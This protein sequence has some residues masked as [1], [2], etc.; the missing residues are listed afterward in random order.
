MK[1]PQ[2]KISRARC[3]SNFRW[4]IKAVDN[5][6]RYTS[7]CG[8]FWKGQEYI[9][10]CPSTRHWRWSWSLISAS[11]PNASKE[12]LDFYDGDYKYRIW[13]TIKCNYPCRLINPHEKAL[14]KSI[15]FIQKSMKDESQTNTNTRTRADDR[16]Y[17]SKMLMSVSVH[18]LCSV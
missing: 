6:R 10:A 4:K 14:K 13:Y 15:K 5:N 17:K 1:F 16:A 8:N 9:V 7:K 11:R 2:K 18:C 12:S 3:E